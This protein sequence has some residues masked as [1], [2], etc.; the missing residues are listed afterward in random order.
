[1]NARTYIAL[2]VIILVVSALMV[3]NPVAFP[4]KK[5]DSGLPVYLAQRMMNNMAR[6]VNWGGQTFNLRL[7]GTVD[8]PT[9]EAIKLVTGGSEQIDRWTFGQLFKNYLI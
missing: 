6:S 5:G 1:M 2:M 9:L 3:Y 7:T 4:L 8:E